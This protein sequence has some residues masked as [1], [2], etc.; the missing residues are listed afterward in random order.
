MVP[1]QMGVPIRRDAHLIYLLACTKHIERSLH[2]GRML[3]REGRWFAE[4]T[5]SGLGVSMV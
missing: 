1:N 4:I 5:I 2:V 3:F